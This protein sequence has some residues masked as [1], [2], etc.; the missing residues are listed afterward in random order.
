M[1][2]NLSIKARLIFIVSFVSVLLLGG[3]AI[4]LYGITENGKGLETVYEDRTVPLVDLGLVIDMVN[5][6][7]T[8]MV[9]TV[10]AGMPE[11]AEAA[12]TEVEVAR[13]SGDSG[14][15]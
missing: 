8:N 4:G 7:R 1:F 5:R 3:A 13:W 14:G 10:N 6:I 11:V 2:E 15:R 9:I 12:R